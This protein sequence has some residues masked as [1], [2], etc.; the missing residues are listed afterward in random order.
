MQPVKDPAATGAPAR[1]NK[2][3]LPWAKAR[4]IDAVI[5]RLR[6]QCAELWINSSEPLAGL[7]AFKRV[8]D[9]QYAG[10]GPLAGLLTGL[11]HLKAAAS[12][13]EWLLSVPCDTPLLPTDLAQQL[14]CALDE[15]ALPAAPGSPS[16]SPIARIATTFERAHPVIGLWHV[17][18]G[19]VLTEFLAAGG[20]KVHAWA[21]NIQALPVTFP[22]EGAFANLNTPEQWAQWQPRA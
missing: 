3:L 5:N 21:S 13:H 1:I 20:F 6:P 22:D 18:H 10:A 2:A 16:Q 4:L 14:A 19:T 15:Q 8:P 9:A 11:Q 17:S 12:P 7:D